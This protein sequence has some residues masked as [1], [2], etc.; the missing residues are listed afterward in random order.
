MPNLLHL[1]YSEINA[2]INEMKSEQQQIMEIYNKTKGMVDGLAGDE[3][4][5]EAAERFR[6]DMNDLHLPKLLK[7]ANVLIKMPD[8][9]SKLS[10]NIREAD[11]STKAF[12]NKF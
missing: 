11:L 9:A 1:K 2:I 4:Q 7:V 5:G 8:V 10:N 3:W 6:A 12:Y